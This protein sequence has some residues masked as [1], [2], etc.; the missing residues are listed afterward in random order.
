MDRHI[1]NV[2]AAAEQFKAVAAEPTLRVT[3]VYPTTH[4]NETNVSIIDAIANDHP[5]IYQV[6]IPNNGSI[7]SVADDVAVE[8]PALVSA[9]GIQ[10]LHVGDLPRPIT[11]HMLDFIQRME[12]NVETFR[13]RDQGMLLDAL[14]LNPQTRSLEDAKACLAELLALPYNRDMAEWYAS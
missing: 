7:P 8:V 6:N 14:M 13:S 1:E 3:D 2:T 10:G 12:R 5:A 4:T 9:A 11:M